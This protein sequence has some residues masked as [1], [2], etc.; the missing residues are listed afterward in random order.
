M[1]TVPNTRGLVGRRGL[2]E[3]SARQMYN[4]YLRL[5]SLR[6]AA[7]LHGRSNQALHE[8]FVRRGW[9]RVA[10]NLQTIVEYKGRR[11]TPGKGGYLRDTAVREKRDGKYQMARGREVRAGGLFEVQLNR[12]VW[13]DHHGPIPAG[14]EIVFLDGNKMNC[15]IEN[16][17]CLSPN[18]SRQFSS[19]GVNQF[20]K[21]APVRLRMMLGHFEAGGQSLAVR[22]KR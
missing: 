4:D 20:T 9:P 18:A 2:D 5:K 15:S 19:K 6:G 10:R 11:F 14:Y 16:L 7:R 21:T 22:M 12:Q 17:K 3:A 8:V 1:S 13:V